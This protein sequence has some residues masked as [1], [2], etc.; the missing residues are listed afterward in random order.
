M[1][2]QFDPLI[3][4][5]YDCFAWEYGEMMGLSQELVGH[6]LPIEEQFRPFK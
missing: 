4:E 6:W 2:P 1:A 5:Y 3:N